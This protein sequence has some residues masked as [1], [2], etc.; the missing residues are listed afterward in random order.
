MRP[1]PIFKWPTSELPICPSGKPTASPQ[2][3]SSVLGYLL[4]NDF[5]NGA[6]ALAMASAFGTFPCP[7][8]S[9]MISI[10]FFDM[11]AKVRY[12]YRCRQIT[13]CPLI[14]IKYYDYSFKICI[15]ASLP[16]KKQINRRR[17]EI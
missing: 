8:P 3:T 12:S 16:R 14:A 10:A 7:Q 9:M 2:V 4:Y 1:A 17:E 11:A 6:L 15:L 5:T 13:N